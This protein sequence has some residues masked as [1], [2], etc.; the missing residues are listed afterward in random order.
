MRRL[1]RKPSFSSSSSRAS[2]EDEEKEDCRHAMERARVRIASRAR[3]KGLTTEELSRGTRARASDEGDATLE[4]NA[5]AH[6]LSVPCALAQSAVKF[7]RAQTIEGESG[8]RMRE[9][10]DARARAYVEE[11]LRRRRGDDAPTGDFHSL[12]SR[13]NVD[14]DRGKEKWLTG[15][16]E[17]AI[18]PETRLRNIEETERAKR[19]M[20][21]RAR[22]GERPDLGLLKPSHVD[23][24]EQKKRDGMSEQAKARKQFAVEFGGKRERERAKPENVEKREKNKAFFNKKKKR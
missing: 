15:I 21:E 22:F 17:V 12:T 4:R 8:G 11:E 9:D 24:K 1:R 16:E 14:D 23:V 5:N 20:L 3:A 18:A 13:A 7:S 10:E 2:D 19:A 6:S